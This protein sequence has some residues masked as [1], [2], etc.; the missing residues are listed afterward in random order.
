MLTQCSQCCHSRREFW[1][2][3]TVVH[4]PFSLLLHFDEVAGLRTQASDSRKLVTE[5]FFYPGF[6]ESEIMHTCSFLSWTHCT[7]SSLLASTHTRMTKSNTNHNSSLQN[8]WSHI[9]HSHSL[10]CIR[11]CATVVCLPGRL[12]V[13][14]CPAY[15]SHA[16]G[17]N[18]LVKRHVG[19][20]PIRLLHENDVTYCNEWRPVKAWQLKRYTRD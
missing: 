12:Q 6:S 3:G 16:E 17:K 14:S 15:F 10:L 1:S 2:V 18:S 13:V 5:W 7:K 11:S 19:G 9:F 8:L 20:A 4:F